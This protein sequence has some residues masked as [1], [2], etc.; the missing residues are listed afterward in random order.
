MNCELIA[1]DKNPTKICSSFDTKLKGRENAVHNLLYT[2]TSP[3]LN[4]MFI[5]V[6]SLPLISKSGL[7]VVDFVFL[8]RSEKER[9][10]QAKA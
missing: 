10:K 2:V 6:V 8:Q 9:V 1:N 7:G 5:K 3:S 4:K